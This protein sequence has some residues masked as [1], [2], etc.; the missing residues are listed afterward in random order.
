LNVEY[1]QV[2]GLEILVVAMQ[3]VVDHLHVRLKKHTECMT[4]SSLC[5]A[6][7][8]AAIV[9]QSLA[10]CLYD[11]GLYKQMRECID[12]LEKS[13]HRKADVIE[14]TLPEYLVAGISVLIGTSFQPV[15]FH[16]VVGYPRFKKHLMLVWSTVMD[17]DGIF[18][19][20]DVGTL[21]Q[22]FHKWLVGMTFK[23]IVGVNESDVI[24][25]CQFNAGITGIAEA[26]ILLVDDADALVFLC[27]SVAEL[28]TA[29]GRSVIDEDHLHLRNILVQHT[30]NTSVE[31]VL[32]EIDG[33]DNTQFHGDKGSV[34]RAKYQ[35]FLVF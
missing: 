20:I 1:V 6:L 2:V 19:D 9:I 24:S 14:Q 31:C 26:A 12:V 4:V 15:F 21:L 16:V 5:D 3:N 29:V 23:I 17:I 27:P 11:L 34:N 18:Q 7:V 25:R 10:A 32:C 13:A 35:I 30:P 28:R 22:M 8:V 33:N